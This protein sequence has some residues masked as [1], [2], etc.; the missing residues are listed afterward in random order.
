MGPFKKFSVFSSI[1][2]FFLYL[3]LQILNF[4]EFQCVFIRF[5]LYIT[6]FIMITFRYYGSFFVA[7]FNL[8]S[9]WFGFEGL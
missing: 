9:N 6:F 4:C 8:K 7:F 2:R 1:F 3:L 5:F